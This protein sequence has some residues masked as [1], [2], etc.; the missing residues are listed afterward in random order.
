MPKD[1]KSIYVPQSY[2]YMR[3]STDKQDIESQKSD[4]KKYCEEKK[5]KIDE[6]NVFMDEG[7]S[8]FKKSWKD[9]K[10]KQIIDKIKQDDVIICY[11]ISRLGRKVFEIFEL[12]DIIAKKKAII[13]CLKNGLYFNGNEKDPKE[14]L[15]E[16]SKL[17]WF[18]MYAELER[19]MISQRTR[20]GLQAIKE[21]KKCK[22]DRENF[23]GICGSVRLEK[24]TD[25]SGKEVIRQIAR[26]GTTYKSKYDDNVKNEIKRLL[27]DG[28]TKKK[29][30]E[31]LRIPYSSICNLTKGEKSTRVFNVENDN[32]DENEIDEF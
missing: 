14:R 21:N 26:K 1:K 8:G 23:V 11:D 27:L 5:I 13:I 10:I 20:S 3:C 18:S 4:I 28:M 30:S 15:N 22:K 12:V 2:F 16:M 9:R 24:T 7:V 29:I 19:N 25:D 32:M 31:T 6:K 17:M